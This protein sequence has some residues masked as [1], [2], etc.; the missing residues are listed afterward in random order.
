MA[1]RRMSNSLSLLVLRARKQWDGLFMR[2]IHG[3]KRAFGVALLYSLLGFPA[4]A[5]AAVNVYFASSAPPA[6]QN[7][8]IAAVTTQFPS[9]LAPGFFSNTWTITVSS[10]NTPPPCGATVY[11]PAQIDTDVNNIVAVT[12]ATGVYMFGS[13]MTY[14]QQQEEGLI[15]A[16]GQLC[17]SPT[18][19]NLV[20]TTPST[21]NPNT[22]EDVVGTLENQLFNESLSTPTVIPPE[23]A[24]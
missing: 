8:L 11:L 10:M 4:L 6:L 21:F 2:K 18:D 20:Q 1:I 22:C 12:T 7:E 15:G 17:G 14:Q 3:A 24:Q 19:Y 13:G 9:T 23:D 5:G 16:M